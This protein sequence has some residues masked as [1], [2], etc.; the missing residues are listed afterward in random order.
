[1]DLM[2][3]TLFGL[4][5]LSRKEYDTL[6]ADSAALTQAA[7]E[8]RESKEALRRAV[9]RH[10]TPN[11]EREAS[12]ASGVPAEVVREITETRG[13]I[14]SAVTLINGISA[15]IQAAVEAALAN[16]ATAEE[17]APVTEALAA[18]DADANELAAAVQANTAG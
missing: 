16:G 14:Q 10:R 4:V 1:M 2:A 8:L 7:G 15:R 13:V 17:L 6:L 18:L 12:M 11:P 3:I 9:E 5:L